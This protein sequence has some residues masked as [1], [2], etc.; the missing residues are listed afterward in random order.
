M[1]RAVIAGFDKPISRLVIG[2]LVCSTDTQ[3]ETN[4]LLDS[5]IAAGGNCI[6]TAHVYGEKS[7]RAVGQWIK[8]RGNRD[9]IV[10]IGKGAHHDSS[11]SRVHAQGIEEDILESLK[12]FQA[13]YIDIYLLHRDDTSVPVGPVVEALNI[14]LKAGRIRAFGGSNWSTDRIQEANTYAASHALTG[15]IASSPYYGLAVANGPVWPGCIS[16]DAAGRKWHEEHQFPLFPWSSQAG[17][18]FTGRFSPGD[19]DTSDTGR[20][21]YSDINWE[22][23]ARAREMGE[24]KGCTANNIA[25][26]YV[27][28][29]PFPVF[30]LIGPRSVEELASSLPA[31]DIHLTAYDILY[32]EV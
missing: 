25:L 13:D 22:R 6:D 17:G 26:A 12:R 23:L 3:S 19:G 11:G 20:T 14:H 27:L 30:P 31:L 2:S 16:L 7:E 28:H 9:S 32:L 8:D 5:Y 15:F 21:Y 29:L 18:F 10:L 24:A 4:E 1:N